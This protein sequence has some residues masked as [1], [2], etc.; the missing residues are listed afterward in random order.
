L[1]F[2]LTPLVRLETVD[3][4]IAGTTVLRAVDWKLE[5]GTCWGVVGANGSGKSTFLALVA[6]QIWPAPGRGS[7]SYDLGRGLERDAVEAR[8]VIT[9]VGHELQDRFARWGWNYKVEDV[10]LSGAARTDIPRRHPVPAHRDRVRALLRELKLDSLATRHFLELSRGEQRRVLIA[11][12]LAFQPRV[13][14]LD[15]PASGLDDSARDSLNELVTNAAAATTIVCS[16]HAV[17]DLPVAVTDV[18]VLVDGEIVARGPRVSL[19]LPLVA[20]PERKPRPT[21]R[22]AESAQVPLV[23]VDHADVWLGGRR[24]LEDVSWR[25]EPGEQWLIGGQ[26]GAGKSTFLK[27]LHGQ[28]RPARGGTLRW[29]AFSDSRGSG[30]LCGSGFSRDSSP[31]IWRL[32]RQIGY[33]SAELQ[34]EYRYAA[35]VH[36]CV[37]SGLDSSI[38]LTRALTVREKESTRELLERFALTK[39]AERSLTTL[40]YGE[41]HR[42]L[43]ART[44]INRPRLLLLDEPWEGLDAATRAL[45]RGELEAAI[46]DGTHLVCVSHVGAAGLDYTNVAEIA[47]GRIVAR[48]LKRA[49]AGAALPENSANERRR[50][51]DY[52]AR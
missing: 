25:L 31:N 30:F 15:E 34:A 7:R 24:I 44:L 3:V 47:D 45:V 12:A 4:T 18:L 32:R 13:L 1:G 14:L 36:E 37:A 35:T 41:M 17:P 9:L 52:R 28:L 16:A 10:V 48:A 49:D 38:G 27:L 8:R 51:R 40:S 43:L 46:A 22:R 11:R 20:A 29:P 6:G 42:V 2:S 21:K 39:L 5:P 50:A 19:T 26:N 23:E 33:V